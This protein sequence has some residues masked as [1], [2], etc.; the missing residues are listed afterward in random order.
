MDFLLCIV[1]KVLYIFW[2][3]FSAMA[4]GASKFFCSLVLV[5]RKLILFIDSIDFVYF[6]F[7]HQ[8]SSI[9]Y[10]FCVDGRKFSILLL[11]NYWIQIVFEQFLLFSVKLNAYQT[12]WIYYEIPRK[13]L[14][15]QLVLEKF[16]SSIM[17]MEFCLQ[18]KW[19]IVHCYFMEIYRFHSSWLLIV[20]VPEINEL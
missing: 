20:F 6:F 13:S 9:K 2:I 3:K 5:G 16:V 14:K 17:V 19:F 15:Y 11:C 1:Y 18:N 8:F 12:L 4:A 7:I 10:S